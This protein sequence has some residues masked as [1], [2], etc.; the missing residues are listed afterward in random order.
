MVVKGRMLRLNEASYLFRARGAHNLEGILCALGEYRALCCSRCSLLG[1]E[2][3]KVGI[4]HWGLLH[5]ITNF[6]EQR[7]LS[8]EEYKVGTGHWGLLHAITC[9]NEQRALSIEED[10]I[11]AGH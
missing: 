8:R 1:L 9:F 6:N 2:E 10:K 4:G 7:A 11:D 5:A 3:H